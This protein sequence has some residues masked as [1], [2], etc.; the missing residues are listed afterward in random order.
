MGTKKRSNPIYILTLFA[1]S[2]LSH[3]L[4]YS[5]RHG[6]IISQSMFHKRRTFRMPSV[7]D[8]TLQHTRGGGQ[9]GTTA[10]WWS[11]NYR[12]VDIM[13]IKRNMNQSGY[14]YKNLYSNPVWY[15]TG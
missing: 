3:T 11:D 2:P 6:Y 1:R 5:V 13:P 12:N 8:P 7:G 15:D 14:A 10:R 9:V 4:V